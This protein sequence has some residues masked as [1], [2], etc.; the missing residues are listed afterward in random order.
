MIKHNS[1]IRNIAISQSGKLA[2]AGYDRK[3]ILWASDSH[4]ALHILEGHADL[5]ESVTFSRDSSRLFSSSCDYSIIEWDVLTGKK[6]KIYLGHEDDVI[7]SDNS[8]CGNYLVSSSSDKT[9]IL[10]NNKGEILERFFSHNSTVNEVHFSPNGKFF[11]SCSNDNKLII[12]FLENKKEIL[13]FD[14]GTDLNSFSWISD[15]EIVS[16]GDDGHC[17]F[18]NIENNLVEKK[19]AHNA[20]VKKVLFNFFKNQIITSSYDKTIKIWDYKNFR[21]VSMCEG[22]R[23][24]ENAICVSSDGNK[25]FTGSMDGIFK[26]YNSIDFSENFKV[27]CE[28]HGLNTIHTSENLIATGTDDNYIY[29]WNMNGILIKKILVHSALVQVV[30]ISPCG[31][32]VA[33][34]S[35]DEK[36]V[37]TSIESEKIVFE[38]TIHNGIVNGLVWANGSDYLISSGYDGKIILHNLKYNSNNI[39]F[40]I[41]DAVKSIQ[42]SSRFNVIAISSNDG[43]VRVIDLDG[44]LLYESIPDSK[45]LNEIF[46]HPFEFKLVSVGRSKKI[47]IH[48]IEN[49]CILNKFLTVSHRKSIK[50][51]SWSCDGKFIV[52][53]SYDCSIKIWSFETEKVIKQIFIGEFGVSRVRFNSNKNSIYVASWDGFLREINYDGTIVSQFNHNKGE[54]NEDCKAYE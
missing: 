37:V 36:V 12:Y 29:L 53:G 24:W 17:S 32:Y 22:G 10:W 41:N 20:S 47:L 3:V 50:S 35:Y 51:V 27:L 8:P 44:K 45:L 46:W 34:G 54:C 11:A 31:K 6:L 13:T 40:N 16:V 21:N 33:S 18:I 30:E 52:T 5:V 26:S 42:W 19:M 1:V 2:T 28:T 25:I 15:F 43:K 4:E 14:L 23:K 38:S 9:V 49:N 39:I 48:D 7:W